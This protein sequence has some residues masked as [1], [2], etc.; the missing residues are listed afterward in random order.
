M[1]VL[2]NSSEMKSCDVSTMMQYGIPSEV[3]MERAALAVRDAAVK[4]FHPENVLVLCGS[5]N[6]G[7][8]GFAAA[9]F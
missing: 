9:S 8:D 4:H 6:N 5:G 1:K 7:G 3:L 2:L